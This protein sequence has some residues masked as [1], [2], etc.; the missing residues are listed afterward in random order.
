MEKFENIVNIPMLIKELPTGTRVIRLRLHNKPN[1][2]FKYKQCLSYPPI[3]N[4]HLMRANLE[5]QQIFYG[6]IFSEEDKGKSDSARFTC[7][8]ETCKEVRD[9]NFIGKKEG[10]YS[11]WISRRPIILFV[12]PI[13]DSYKKTAIDF[14][15]YFEFWKKLISEREI[16]EETIKRLKILSDNFAFVPSTIEEENN[17]YSYTAS[18][19]NELLNSNKAIDGIIYPSARLDGDGIGINVA[20]R[21]DVIDNDFELKYSSICHLFKRSRELQFLTTYKTSRIAPNGKI[22]YLIDKNYF[23]S[24]DYINQ[25]NSNFNTRDLIFKY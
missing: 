25:K 3:E 5:N 16:P 11:L 8:C 14:Q 1:Q 19:T 2:E 17:C 15:W 6:S 9:D 23:H 18:F 4:S 20:I 24:I 10:S 13:F 12:V 22:K 21:P 7:L